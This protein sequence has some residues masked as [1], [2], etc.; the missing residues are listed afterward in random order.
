MN[1]KPR[2]EKEELEMKFC[3]S[4]GW[5]QKGLSV[6]KAPKAENHRD[7]VTG[8]W[9]MCRDMRTEI[10]SKPTCGPDAK[11]FKEKKERKDRRQRWV[12]MAKDTHTAS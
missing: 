11:W 6:C 9:P 10:I 4:C 1:V 12:K 3:K 8:D 7:P 2:S 5:K